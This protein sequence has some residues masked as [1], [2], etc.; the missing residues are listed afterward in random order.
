MMTS[1]LIASLK[2]TL[3]SFALIIGLTQC[4]DEEELIA[5][6]VAETVTDEESADTNSNIVSIS[7]SGVY[8]EMKEASTCSTCTYTVEAG[9]TVIDGNEISFKPG[10]VICLSKDVNYGTL[11]FTNMEGT[12]DE[13]IVIMK[14][15]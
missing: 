11:E 9:T 8:T 6:I 3:L 14:L 12:A 7:I 13:P 10:S 2:Y 5:P 15:E 4:T 1:K